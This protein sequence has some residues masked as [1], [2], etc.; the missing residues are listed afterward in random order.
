M[1]LT[2]DKLPRRIHTLISKPA[3]KSFLSPISIWEAQQLHRRKRLKID[4]DFHKWLA[5]A[6]LLVP[7]EEASITSAIASQAG[8][9]HLPEP[10]FGDL[11]LAATAI[12]NDLTLI[13]ADTQLLDCK[14]LKTLP[15]N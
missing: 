11:F 15:A 14:W 7:L 3:S 1:I 12:V 2:P 13:T 9:L 6:F 4:Q 8:Q 5:K 10:D